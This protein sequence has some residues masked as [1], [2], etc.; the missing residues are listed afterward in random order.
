[1]NKVKLDAW[2]FETK[3]LVRR[4]SNA[5]TPTSN[6]LSTASPFSFCLLVPTPP[7][8]WGSGARAA[9]PS[10]LLCQGNPGFKS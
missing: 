1:M 8:P 9:C 5:S 6:S 4:M 2:Y 10:Y 3:S 7:Q